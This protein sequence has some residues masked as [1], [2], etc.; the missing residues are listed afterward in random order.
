[1]HTVA[2]PDCGTDVDVGVDSE[3]EVVEVN[4]ETIMKGL[5]RYE[6]SC[7]EGHEFNVHFR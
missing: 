2:C 1:M 7:P 5:H 4:H 3:R 6:A